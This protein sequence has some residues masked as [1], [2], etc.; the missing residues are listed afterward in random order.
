MI[1]S[2]KKY[3]FRILVPAED[4]TD[5][6]DEIFIDKEYIVKGIT[7]EQG[8]LNALMMLPELRNHVGIDE[9]RK[10]SGES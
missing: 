10:N 2:E 1:L 5:D 4:G 3:H 9:V 6:I 8:V 7:K